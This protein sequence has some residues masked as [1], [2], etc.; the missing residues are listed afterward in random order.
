M[1]IAGLARFLRRGAGASRL[2][3]GQCKFLP[4]RRSGRQ[5]LSQKSRRLLDRP[6]QIVRRHALTKNARFFSR[7][8][9]GLMRP[10]GERHHAPVVFRGAFGP[11]ALHADLCTIERQAPPPP[12]PVSGPRLRPRPRSALADGWHQQHDR[13]PGQA[14][15][16]LRPGAREDPGLSCQQLHLACRV[17]RKH[18]PIAL[19]G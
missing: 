10:I 11:S 19:P 8:P 2:T 4:R 16:V 18:P 17:G 6:R 7:A 13:F 5:R 15:Q 9:L 3:R 14:G 1:A 12:P